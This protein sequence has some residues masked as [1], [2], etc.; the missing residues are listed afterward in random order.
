MGVAQYNSEI[1]LA[2]EVEVQPLGLTEAALLFK[3]CSRRKVLYF[4][5]RNIQYLENVSEML[6]LTFLW[7]F[8]FGLLLWGNGTNVFKVI[9]FYKQAVTTVTASSYDPHCKPLF[10]SGEKFNCG[11]SNTQDWSIFHHLLPINVGYSEISPLP[12][13]SRTTDPY[14]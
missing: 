8:A 2:D 4:D 14:I 9:K 1:H 3:F 6:T 13:F 12:P 10:I 11:H 5:T 7:N